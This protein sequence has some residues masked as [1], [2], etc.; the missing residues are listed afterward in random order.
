MV[1]KSLIN[2][3]LNVSRGLVAHSSAAFPA[4]LLGGKGKVLG[5][6]R[7]KIVPTPLSL[8]FLSPIGSRFANCVRRNLLSVQKTP[9][10]GALLF[11]LFVFSG[12]GFD[13]PPGFACLFC[14]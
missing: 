6:F 7:Y 9:L 2:S 5:P 14:C 8:C 1:L 13:T 12:S 10:K 11:F 3:P 4:P